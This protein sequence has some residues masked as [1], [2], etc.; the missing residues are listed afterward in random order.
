[1]D[2]LHFDGD[3]GCYAGR[4]LTIAGSAM[5]RRIRVLTAALVEQGR[6]PVDA[7]EE[8]WNTALEE[9]SWQPG[10]DGVTSHEQHEDGPAIQRGGQ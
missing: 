1:M 10:E 8:A 7:A 5:N 2:R 6:D 9:Q 3:S 4:H